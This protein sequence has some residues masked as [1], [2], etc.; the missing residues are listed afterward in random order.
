L[1][2]KNTRARALALAPPPAQ[3]KKNTCGRRRTSS[4]LL[5][6]SHAHA[7]P[8]HSEAFA[9]W[10]PPLGVPLSYAVAIGYVLVDTV[11]KGLKAYARAREEL[12]G[13]AVPVRA[14]VDT[15][16]LALLLAAER[17]VDT[18]VWQLLA[19]VFVPGYTIHTVVAAVHA[20]LGP[21]EALPAVQDAASG[22]ASLVGAASGAALLAVADKS[23]PTVA[24]LA[25]ESCGVV[26][27]GEGEDRERGRTRRVPFSLHLFPTPLSL[28]PP[29]P[30]LRAS[31]PL[32][33]PPDRQRH[34]RPAEH[35]AAPGPEEGGVR[36]RAG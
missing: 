25:G 29:P 23:L 18:I 20:G 21:L 6:L 11:D 10:L 22:L 13:G 1:T 35:H 24:G 31:H 3:K 36:G 28:S 17:T 32:H 12:E 4:S 34:P 15:G 8:I 33:R 2:K 30:P 7:L 14:D 9:A 27:W 26:G 16:R 19:S 5:S